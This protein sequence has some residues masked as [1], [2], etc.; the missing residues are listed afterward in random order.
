MSQE[1]KL[2]QYGIEKRFQERIVTPSAFGFLGFD[3]NAHPTIVAQEVDAAIDALTD[4]TTGTAGL[5]LA[6]NSC[7]EV[8]TIGPIP[9]SAIA[10]TNKFGVTVPFAFKLLSTAIKAQ[11]PAT[12]G[13]K[14]TTLTPEIAGTPTTGGVLTL[15]SLNQTPTNTTTAGTSVSAANVGTAGQV[16]AVLASST[17]AFVEGYSS[18]EFT[19]L[20]LD[21]A[22]AIASLA[23]TLNALTAALTAQGLVAAA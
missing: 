17:T 18:V 1:I 15:T 5:T 8:I 9:L 3:A 22:A 4:S 16:L 13:S 23:A 6:L 11:K 12:T 21:K 14:G 7:K 19:V 10:D 2:Q 20:N